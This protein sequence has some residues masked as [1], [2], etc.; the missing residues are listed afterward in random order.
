MTCHDADDQYSGGHSPIARPAA[1]LLSDS[2]PLT[3]TWSGE[4]CINWFLDHGA[5][6]RK[7]NLG[8]PL[9]GTGWNGTEGMYSNWTS[10]IVSNVRSIRADY[11]V[12]E[13]EVIWF[14]DSI[15]IEIFLYKGKL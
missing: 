6:A 11:Q 7:L 5:T 13:Q 15:T 2:N 8:M 10:T 3:S 4:R 9:Y 12:G 1:N 14:L